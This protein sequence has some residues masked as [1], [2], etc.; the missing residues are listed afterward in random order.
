MV[1]FYTPSWEEIHNDVIN[2]SNNIL[3]SGFKPDVIVAVARGGWVVGRL[4]SDILNIK[5]V[6]NIRIEFYSDISE[7]IE[8]PIIS[9]PISVDPKNKKILLCDDVS[10]TG[11]S[12]SAAV[13]HLNEK[14][15]KMIK[16]ACLHKKPW[17]IL[18]PDYYSKETDKWVIYPWEYRETFEKLL[19]KF[20]KQ[21][22]SIAES[23]SK[24][25]ALNIPRE[26]SEGII[27]LILNEDK[28]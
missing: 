11:K 10:D 15:A 20:K 1:E 14:N 19:S 24:L 13:E 28:I 22:L 18:T 27:N 23:I 26:I 5:N 17:S 8:K 9:Q 21:N 25:R 4:I 16:V 7:T 3:K 2:I 12:L 6:A